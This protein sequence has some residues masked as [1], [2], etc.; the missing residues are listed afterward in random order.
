MDGHMMGVWQ[1]NAAAEPQ[2]RSDTK[3]LEA[4][5]LTTSVKFC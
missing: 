4:A 1:W 3:P 2:L 5:S